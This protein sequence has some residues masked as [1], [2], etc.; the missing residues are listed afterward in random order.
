MIGPGIMAQSTGPCEPCAGEGK[1]VQSVCKACNGKKFLDQEKILEVKIT[2]GM[3]EGETIVFSGECSESAEFESPGD[4]VLTIRRTD[5]ETGW[6]VQGSDLLLQQTVS[7]AE[8]MMGVSFRLK[9]HPSGKSP[10]FVWNKGPLLHGSVLRATGWGMLGGDAL[11]EIHVTA[12]EARAWRPEELLM[13]QTV[14][15]HTPVVPPTDVE[16]VGLEL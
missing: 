2:P 3:K 7:Y 9:D 8:A 1:T 11:I 5:P 14:F 10:L 12:P 6:V 4:V 13:L 15:Q 16:V